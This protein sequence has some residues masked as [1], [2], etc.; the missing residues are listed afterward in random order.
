L[1]YSQG[2]DAVIITMPASIPVGG[3]FKIDITYAG[4]PAGGV[5]KSRKVVLLK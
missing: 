3:T 1:S 5:Q 2:V 4:T